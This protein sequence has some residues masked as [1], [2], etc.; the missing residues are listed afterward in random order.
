MKKTPLALGSAFA[1]V[2]V[3][4]PAAA[5]GPLDG[6]SKA[7]TYAHSSSS[8]YLSEIVSFDSKTSTLWVSG[9]SG[10]DVLDAATGSFLQ[11][12]DTSAFGSIN[13]VSIH[14]GM[15]AFA[16][17]SSTRTNP[18]VV[19]LYD[20]GTRS[21]ASGINSISV[22]ALPDMLTFSKDGTKLLVA[23][24][25]SPSTYG[26]RLADTNGHRNYGPA[27]LDPAG[28]VSIIDMNSRSVAATAT[29][30][31]VAQSGSH[32][33][34]NTGMDFEPEYIAV[35]GAGTKAYVSLQE[36]NAMGVLN[37]QTLSFEKVIGLGAKDFSAP[38][39]RIDPLNNGNASLISVN[40]KGLYMPDGMAAYEAAGKTFVV[41]ANEGDFREDD[42]D[43]SAASSFGAAAPLNALRVSN[44]DSST[45]DLYAAGARSFSIRDENGDLV[46]DSGEILDREAIALGIYDDGRSRDKGVEPEGVELM[47]IGGRTF[48]FVGLERTTKGAIAVFDITDPA[49]SSFVQMLVSNGDLAPEGLKGYVLNGAY[50]LAFSNEASN[51]TS[52]YQLAAVPEPETYAL[53]L[54]GLGLIAAVARRKG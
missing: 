26:P 41:M 24:E 52:V 1:A 38:G 42:G 14:N 29:L 34:N 22:G 23:N 48:A 32:I 54:A 51:T 35:N 28:S 53:M 49:N 20:T 19:K 39:N 15:A 25:A 2:L 30:A 17:E 40:A 21:L 50:Y 46:Y 5:A 27:A 11:R 31:G 36:A 18:G 9:I 44:T 43:R 47:D 4:M 16:I 37:L 8:G 45:G 33:R 6:A 10:V 13:S 12:V 3:A 7:W